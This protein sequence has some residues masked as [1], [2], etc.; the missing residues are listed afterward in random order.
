M[1][2]GWLLARPYVDGSR[3]IGAL[4]L[5]AI[6]IAVMMRTRASPMWLVG[7]GAVVGALGWI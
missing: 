3:A 4:A 7:L 2:T 5:M 1:A 6:S